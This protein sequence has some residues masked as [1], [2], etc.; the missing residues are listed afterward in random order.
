MANIMGIQV[1]PIRDKEEAEN[2]LRQTM[3]VEE[4]LG[5]LNYGDIS[6]YG[7]MR[8]YLGAMQSLLE[9]KRGYANA[10]SDTERAIYSQKGAINRKLAEDMGIDISS[11]A[12]RYNADEYAE[13]LKGIENQTKN[14]VLYRKH[15]D[16]IAANIYT[17]Y[18]KQGVDE[19]T[20]RRRTIA[21]VMPYA[22]QYESMAR[23]SMNDYGVKDGA[24][25]DAAGL[26]LSGMSPQAAQINSALYLTP[27]D[28]RKYG[29]KENL[30]HTAAD[31]QSGQ[32]A[33]NYAQQ[34]GLID[35]RGQWGQSNMRLESGLG[36][37]QDARR[38]AYNQQAADNELA[39]AI[40][41][42][43]WLYN[44]MVEKYGEEPARRAFLQQYGNQGSQEEKP[45]SD[46]QI[47]RTIEAGQLLRDYVQNKKSDA[48]FNDE[49]AQY[50]PYLDDEM[51][52]YIKAAQVVHAFVHDYNDGGEAGSNNKGQYW[53][54]TRDY[55]EQIMGNEYSRKLAEQMGLLET[56]KK[57]IAR[58]DA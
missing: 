25:M 39:R 56:V 30:M 41:G 15:P 28:M 23:Y 37:E 27:A 29:E 45:L 6:D 34:L 51:K 53:K 46:K 19:G 55:A 20:A 8:N 16:E 36:A 26:I 44:F 13:Y 12:D 54:N 1:P 38:F 42:K 33:Q 9:N 31:I 24:M 52:Q 35:K 48:E 4:A 40:K 50:T 3:G 22:T 7:K 2:I 57:V 18:L 5:G 49:I 58:K 32:S 14:R 17:D 11:A 10:K 43:E 47:K 21:E